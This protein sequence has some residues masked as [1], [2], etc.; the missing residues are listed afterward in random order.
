MTIAQTLTT[1]NAHPSSY[2][3]VEDAS[4]SVAAADNGLVFG[5]ERTLRPS[6]ASLEPPVTL[7][8]SS[9]HPRDVSTGRD[10][11][12]ERLPPS[13]EVVLSRDG[14]QTPAPLQEPRPHTTGPTTYTFSTLSFNSMLLLPPS[15]A[16]DTRPLYHVSVAHNCFMPLSYITTVRKGG[17][18]NG[19]FVGDF[20]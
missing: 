2:A 9:D 13:P 4:E 16:I 6:P 3:T 15:D 19:E 1:G 10:Q 17:T 12:I 7:S 14:T 20:E 5:R 18:E 8:S 11:R